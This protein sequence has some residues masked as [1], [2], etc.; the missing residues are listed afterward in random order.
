MMP[1]SFSDEEIDKL[2]SLAAAL[3]P[4]ARGDF[5]RIVADKLGSIP[6]EVRG[7]GLVHRL[8]AEAQR[9][10]VAA[11]LAVGVEKHGTRPVRR[12]RRLP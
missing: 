2:T 3:P 12:Q 6:F 8:A 7:P 9:A 5:L 1:L 11:P 10:F 4:A